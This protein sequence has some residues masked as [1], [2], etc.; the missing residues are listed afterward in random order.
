MDE[1]ELETTMSLAFRKLA[2]QILLRRHKR[3]S[4][5]EPDIL[6]LMDGHTTVCTRCSKGYHYIGETPRKLLVIRPKI[7]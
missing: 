6:E 1:D 3:F 4:S 2:E 5:E 7:T